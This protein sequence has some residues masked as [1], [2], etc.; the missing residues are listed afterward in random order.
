MRFSHSC[1]AATTKGEALCSTCSGAGSAVNHNAARPL[2]APHVR[3]RQEGRQAH[4]AQQR[5][6]P[7]RALW[8]GAHLDINRVHHQE[9]NQPF[10]YSGENVISTN[11]LTACF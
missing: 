5:K 11:G 6:R 7:G 10:M 4:K 3:L 2:G 1:L 9:R 8:D